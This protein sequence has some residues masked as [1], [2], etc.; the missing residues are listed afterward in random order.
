MINEVDSRLRQVFLALLRSGLWSHEPDCSLFPLREGEWEKLYI[1]AR[2][3]T[4]EG[5]VYDGILRLPSHWL[6]S[7]P[8]LATWA[9]VVDETERCNKRMNSVL[10]QLSHRL[11]ERGISAWLM[12]G[13]GTALCYDQPFHRRCGDI[14]LYF[15][16]A[17]DG[18]SMLRMMQ[19][20]GVPLTYMPGW[21]VTYSFG[22]FC[23]DQHSRAVDI[24]NPWN[25]RY[26]KRLIQVEVQNCVPWNAEIPSLLLPSPLLA[27]L[28]TNTHILKHLMAVGVGFRQLCDSARIC[29]YY[30]DI[31]CGKELEQ[32]YRR[33]GIYR[34][35][36]TLNRVLVFE[37]GMAP[38]CLPFPLSLTEEAVWMRDVW[39]GGNF[40]FYDQRLGHAS[41][42]SKRKRMADQLL[43]H[44][45][46]QM[47][48]APAEAFWFPLMQFYSR[49][50]KQRI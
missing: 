31:V 50:R 19:A 41:A 39:A 1:L 16:D 24:H 49:Y 34:W 48:Y 46:P 22:S 10:E 25:A 4:V 3:Q 44:L 14:D 40:G 11:S 9:A 38:E 18:V 23:V 37:L 2:Q 42:R 6:P 15:P 47:R 21:S 35:I 12:K 8:F 13:Q 33:L 17:V 26:I 28:V 32:I 45:W 29:K 7:F 43:Y 5:V 36:Q 30:S 20:D 27:H